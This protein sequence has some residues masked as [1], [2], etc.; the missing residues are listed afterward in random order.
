MMISGI[1]DEAGSD[2]KTQISAQKKLGWDAIELRLVDGVNVAGEMSDSCFDE[3]RKEIEK[4]RLTVTAFASA[5]GNWSR[6]VKEDFKVDLNE[7]ATAVGRMRSMGVRG[8][9]VMS[10]K[11]DGIPESEWRTEV[12]RRCRELAKIAEDAGVVLLHENC[13]GWGGLSAENMVILKNEV[14]SPPFKFLY[15]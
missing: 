3:V 13:V 2:I 1:A 11:G 10:W 15:D 9:R 14:H 8:I 4:S 5:I 7:L 12:L 6:H